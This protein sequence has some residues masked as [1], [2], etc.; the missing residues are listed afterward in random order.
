[1][2]VHL[3]EL[4]GGARGEDALEDA[5]APAHLRVQ[6]VAR[7]VLGVA[8]AEDVYGAVL[9]QPQPG[10]DAVRLTTCTSMHGRAGTGCG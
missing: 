5:Q 6:L 8:A 10:V 4:R 7:A 3:L 2:F 9:Q 1:M